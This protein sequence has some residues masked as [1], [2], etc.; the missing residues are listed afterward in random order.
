[1]S[2]FVYENL[3][4]SSNSPT[5]QQQI[6]FMAIPM[7]GLVYFLCM[8]FYFTGYGH[9]SFSS[10]PLFYT[11]CLCSLGLSFVMVYDTRS[12]DLERFNIKIASTT[13]SAD[14]A[15]KL[16]DLSCVVF[17]TMMAL[18]IYDDSQTGETPLGL[19]VIP[20]GRECPYLTALALQEHKITA[21]RGKIWHLRSPS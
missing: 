10:F 9:A 19:A 4:D 8:F 2:T 13:I 15:V 7:M 12:L 18:V 14:T 11:T 3:H 5:D 20:V 16:A 6:A 17:A 21:F 1:M